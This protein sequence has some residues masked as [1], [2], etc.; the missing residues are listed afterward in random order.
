MYCSQQRLA[1]EVGY[2]ADAD[3]ASEYCHTLVYIHFAY[4]PTFPH[5][6]HFIESVFLSFDP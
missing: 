4:L 2:R 1:V 3:L 5:E 6:T